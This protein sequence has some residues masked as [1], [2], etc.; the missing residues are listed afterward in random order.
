MSSE[1]HV[2]NFD[3]ERSRKSL[4]KPLSTKEQIIDFKVIADMHS[5]DPRTSPS[6]AEAWGSRVHAGERK[7]STVCID[8]ML[9]LYPNEALVFRSD[10]HCTAC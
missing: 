8:E 1:G 2:L 5:Y 3:D 6:K 9:I 4:A 10:L 7:V